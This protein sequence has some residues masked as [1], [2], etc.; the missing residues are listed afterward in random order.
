MSIERKRSGIFC[1]HVQHP[2]SELLVSGRKSDEMRQTVLPKKHMNTK[3]YI[4]VSQKPN[5]ATSG[6]IIGWVQFSGCLALDDK[7]QRADLT[8]EAW[9]KRHCVTKEE[10]IKCMLQ[11]EQ[12][13]AW[14]V[15]A[16]QALSTPIPHAHKQ[17]AILFEE[18]SVTECVAVL[19]SDV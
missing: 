7:K 14:H 5:C 4:A 18:L 1:L 9:K 10:H 12:L 19:R 16:S 8:T 3:I 11:K 15:S 13:F 6:Q 2:W 17:G